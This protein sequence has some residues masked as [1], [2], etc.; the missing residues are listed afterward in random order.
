MSAAACGLAGLAPYPAILLPSLARER[1]R[2]PQPALP[3][4]PPPPPISSPPQS[5][6]R[7]S[8]P[9]AKHCSSTRPADSTS[10]PS[11]APGISPFPTVPILE[12]IC[13]LA[14][15]DASA[16]AVRTGKFLCCPAQLLFTPVFGGAPDRCSCRQ[17]A[18]RTHFHCVWHDSC[19]CRTCNLA[20]PIS[21]RRGNIPTSTPSS[22][23]SFFFFAVL[24]RS[25][26]SR[27]LRRH[28]AP[29]G[30]DP[31]C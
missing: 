23:F 31:F 19:V 26:P 6:S 8:N 18:A 29:S 9:V 15:F 1:S 27:P 24:R 2:L 10:R 30:L 17:E 20:F 28:Q 5:P 21:T 25:Q 14:A 13:R 3:L 16:T 11:S 4:F 7:F 22:L 12:S